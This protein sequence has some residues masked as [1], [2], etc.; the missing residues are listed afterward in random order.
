MFRKMSQ[1]ESES[2]LRIMCNHAIRSVVFF[3]IL[4]KTLLSEMLI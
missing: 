3:S 1:S 2:V 4:F